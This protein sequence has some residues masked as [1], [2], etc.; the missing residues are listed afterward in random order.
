[1]LKILKNTREEVH[2]LVTFLDKYLV[3]FFI[4]AEISEMLKK[5]HLSSRPSTE[6]IR[7]LY[8]SLQ[9]Y[10]PDTFLPETLSTATPEINGCFLQYLNLAPL[11]FDLCLC[12][13]MYKCSCKI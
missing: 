3:G 4:F 13:K 5:N 2:F 12:L 8:S 1:M 11:M 6:E 7:L 9:N 10:R